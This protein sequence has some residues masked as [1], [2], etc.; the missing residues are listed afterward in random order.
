M[1]AI[2]A[3]AAATVIIP[4]FEQAALTIA[5]IESLRRWDGALWPIV[6]VDDGS[7]AAAREAVAGRRFANVR[8]VEQPRRGVSAAWNLGATEARTRAVVFL[9]N[10]VQFDGPAL[11]QLVAPMWSGALLTGAA[12]RNERHVPGDVRQ[13]LPLDWFVEGW[14][15]AVTK[16][17]FDELG[18][19]DE[20]MGTYWSDTDLQ[21]RVARRCGE[22]SSTAG[23]S[24]LVC[25]SGLP[26]RHLG[27]RTTA[28]LP[29]R[30]VLWAADRRAFLAKWRRR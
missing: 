16:C 3:V 22:G 19:F 15:F 25:P 24:A 5:C 30:R 14:C 8:V 13:R 12:Y 29:E 2:E 23:Q 9:N 27:H 11:H 21:L 28:M 20:S 10:D 6:V 26:L 18:G 4:Q 1:S 7:S 17:L